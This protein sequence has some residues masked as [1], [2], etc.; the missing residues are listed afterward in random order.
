MIV[1]GQEVYTES[2][3][4]VVYLKVFRKN[5]KRTFRHC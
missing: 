2:L 1:T 5:L 3:Y 4:V